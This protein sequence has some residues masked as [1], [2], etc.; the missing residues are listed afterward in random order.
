MEIKEYKIFAPACEASSQEVN[1]NLT[2][3]EDLTELLPYINREIESA[4]F[5]PKA[6]FLKFMHEGHK[7]VLDHS[8][9]SIAKFADEDSAMKFAAEIMDMLSDIKARKDSIEPDNTAFEPP[10]V[11]EV[12]KLLPRK[13]P[14]NECGYP[15]CMAFAAALRQEE[16]EPRDCKV[17]VGQE[18]GEEKL[19]ALENLLGM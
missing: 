16:A 18:D 12:L 4:R 8:T 17:L 5:N 13:A 15:A 14:C 2:I 10:S 1:Y 19:A 6:S 3:D 7:V 11:I 9:V